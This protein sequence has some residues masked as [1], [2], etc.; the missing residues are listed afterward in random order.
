MAM[1]SSEELVEKYTPLVMGIAR[2]IYHQHKIPVEMDDLF[3]WGM[4]GL[5]ECAQRF[6]PLKGVKFSTF[7][8]Y[9]IRGAIYDG[10]RDS[11]SFGRSGLRAMEHLDEYMSIKSEAGDTAVSLEDSFRALAQ[12]IA[13]A[14]VMKNIDDCVDISSEN[15]S[16]EEDAI[17]R[18]NHSQLFKNIDKLPP[19]EKFVIQEHYFNGRPLKEIAESRNRSKSW[20]SRVHAKAIDILK[21]YFIG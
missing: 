8:W 2:D 14:M 19:T 20:A 12:G 4:A 7:A 13:S 6:D 3:A 10:I 5:L 9:R 18:S 11:G 16:P 21:E 17:E 1:S 15:Q